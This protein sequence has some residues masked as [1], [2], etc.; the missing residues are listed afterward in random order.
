M[1]L[2]L[3]TLFILVFL[4]ALN[5]YLARTLPGGEFFYLRW[6]GAR[7]FLFD[8]IESYGSVVAERTQNIAYG[9]SAF[10]SEYPYVLNDPF[11]IIILYTPLALFS[12]FTIA[13]GLWMLL[14]EISIVGTLYYL[15][16]IIEWDPPRWLFLLITGVVFFGYYGVT[17]LISGTPT[18]ILTFIFILILFALHS[19]HDEIAGAL[20]FLVAYQ[21][22]VGAIFFLFILFMVLANRRWGVLTGF[23]MSLFL[24][25]VA[26]FLAYPAWALP[27]AR[28]VLSDWYH[29]ATMSFSYILSVWFPAS[30]ISIG[31]WISLALGGVLLIEW[32]G[33]IRAN[34]RRIVW[35]ASLTLAVTPLMGFAIFPGNHVVL[36]PALVLIIML[37][38]ERWTRQRIWFVLLVLLITLYVPYN[39]YARVNTNYSRFTSDLLIILPPISTIVGL[40]WMRWWAF[41]SPRTWFDQIGVRK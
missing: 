29:S 37:V 19:F 16:K 22:E 7:A 6:S 35:T 30:R 12:D 23:S 27:Y 3:V 1:Q 15:F 20:L 21:W 5:I 40:Y 25:L 24:L 17:A 18:V 34:F 4:V 9:R 39:L 13:R 8:H 26:S 11:Y 38:W 10:S 36:F 28:G 2:L 33:S 32:V 14:S 31:V 41:R